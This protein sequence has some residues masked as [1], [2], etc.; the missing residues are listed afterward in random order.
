M[1]TREENLKKINDTLE[2]MSDDELEKV[3]GGS[4]YEMADDSRFLNSL[5]GSV[6]R[7]GATKM[8]FHTG[9]YGEELKAA[10]AN[11][12]IKMEYCGDLNLFDNPNSRNKYELNGK[13]IT[14]EEAR[15][16]A[17]KVTGHYITEKD[18]KW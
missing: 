8:Y 14:Q 13:Q 1:A 17:M 16:H 15:Q 12:G 5:N 4:C 18:W 3:S 2:Q 6:N 9:S 10:W 7:Y 11:L